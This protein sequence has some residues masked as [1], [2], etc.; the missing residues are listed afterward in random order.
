MSRNPE[1]DLKVVDAFWSPL[2]R[3]ELAEICTHFSGIGVFESEVRPGGRPLTRS[4]LV[5]AA[6]GPFFVKWRSRQT[7]SAE[8]VAAEHRLIHDLR[9]AGF[10]TPELMTTAEGLTALP[11]A[12]GWVE[13]QACAGGDDR[14]AGRHTWQPFLSV[15][16]ARAV[17]RSLAALHRLAAN[18]HAPAGI[19]RGYPA[20]TPR[21]LSGPFPGSDPR[22]WSPDPEVQAFLAARPSWLEGV[23]LLEP[24]W[25]GVAADLTAFA[26][27][28]IHGDPQANNH[29]FNGE[30]VSAVIDFHLAGVAPRLLDL[31]IA[32]DRNGLMWLEI[33][34]GQTKAWDEPSLRGLLGGYDPLT[35]A[36]ASL[37]PRLL[38]LAQ[39]DFALSLLTYYL[40]VE[41]SETRAAWAW[42][43]FIV[44]H[45]QW[46]ASPEGQ[47]FR[48]ELKK[49]ISAE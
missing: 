2:A 9:A 31:A 36:E 23:L 44:G 5:Q 8:G 17:G 19:D 7:L 12:E 30:A 38:T 21:L 37:L 45:A 24:E 35:P 49:I 4:A 14:Y 32:L 20:V 10:P 13:V 47:R 33:M 26:A 42:D 48:A 18:L 25:N 1:E 15:A 46:H 16:D 11:W 40:S 39:V 28:W 34:A 27:H 22:A 3:E 6:N 41:R 43:V 29:F